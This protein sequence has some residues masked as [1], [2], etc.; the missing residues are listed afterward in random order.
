MTSH[1]LRAT[2]LRVEA[3]RSVWRRYAPG[4][5]GTAIY[6]ASL[7][8]PLGEVPA[9][10][11]T[12]PMVGYPAL[13]RMRML[14]VTA[15]PLV[16]PAVPIPIAPQPDISGRGRRTVFLDARWRRSNCNYGA[17]VIRARGRDSDH[18]STEY[19]R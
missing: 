16:A 5:S 18:T 13:V 15:D 2:F 10:A 6:S 9:I 19:Y 11:L 7:P 12:H 8:V 4:R 3:T 17:D 1:A 14:P